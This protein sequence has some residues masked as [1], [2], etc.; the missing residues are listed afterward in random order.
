MRWVT[1]TFLLI[2]MTSSGVY[3]QQVELGLPMQA[4]KGLKMTVHRLLFPCWMS[5]HS[6]ALCVRPGLVLID[7]D[8]EAGENVLFLGGSLFAEFR[9]DPFWSRIGFGFGIFNR[10][11]EQVRSQ[12]D[13][14]LTV[15][16]GVW[17]TESIGL[18]VG[19]E[20]LSNG[21]SFASRLGLGRYWPD[22]NDGGN[23]LLLIGIWRF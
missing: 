11:T 10:K 22:H 19:W 4:T 6:G 16:Y 5:S 15:N 17:V 18:A 7:G 1:I 2:L 12:W 8:V 14:N 20:H 21:R 3:G 23:A 9:A 13:F